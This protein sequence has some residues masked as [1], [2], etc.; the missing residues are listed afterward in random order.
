[1]TVNGRTPKLLLKDLERLDTMISFIQTNLHERLSIESLAAQFAIGKS[2][3]R[4]HFRCYVQKTIH[5][6]I[7]QCRMEKAMELIRA[8]SA[9]I[10]EISLKVGFEDRTS[11]SRAFTKYW[12]IA[13][14]QII[15]SGDRPSVEDIFATQ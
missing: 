6:F 2:T 7:L 11:F 14:Q 13:P 8:Q 9:L 12:G 3:L 15:Q 10:N 5:A 1:M 4:R